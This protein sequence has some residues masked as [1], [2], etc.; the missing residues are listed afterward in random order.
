MDKHNKEIDQLIK[1]ALGEE[2]ATYYEKLEEEQTLFQE[3]ASIYKGRRAWITIW[4]SFVMV[5]LLIGGIYCLIEFF[6]TDE[7]K[8]LMIWGGGFFFA[9][10][11]ISALKVYAWLQMDR[12][13]IIREMKRL[14]FQVNA[15]VK[16]VGNGKVNT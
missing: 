10:M 11:T 1:E 12:N 8:Q 2:E 16:E 15:L 6:R 9:M 5:V 4:V 7:V 13:A 3:M 14:E